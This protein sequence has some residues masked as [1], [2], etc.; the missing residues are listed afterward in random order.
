ML[1]RYFNPKYFLPKPSFTFHYIYRQAY[2]TNYYTNHILHSIKYIHGL[3]QNSYMFRH[4]DA[5]IKGPFSTK[6]CRPNTPIYLLCYYVQCVLSPVDTN[7]ARSSRMR[8]LRTIEIDVHMHDPYSCKQVLYL[9]K[10][11]FN[12]LIFL[13]LQH[14]DFM[15]VN[16]AYFR[17]SLFNILSAPVRAT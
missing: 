16:F 10:L 9:E 7:T 17:I 13:I 8:S 5:I 2:Y 14:C 12:T 11:T 4:R 1:F 6:E 3:L 15:V